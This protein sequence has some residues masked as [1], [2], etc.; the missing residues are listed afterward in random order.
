MLHEIKTQLGFGLVELGQGIH[1]PLV[2]GIRKMVD[3]GEMRVSSL[4]NFCPL[5]DEGT[6]APP[7]CYMFSAAPIDE[8]EAAV[9][10]PLQTIDFAARLYAPFVVL[11]LGQ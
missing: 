7:D 8:R 3:G 9:A 5:P 2:S 11:H 1:A 4:H 10:Q 6:P